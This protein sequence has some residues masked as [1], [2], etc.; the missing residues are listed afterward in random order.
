MN[1]FNDATAIG[2]MKAKKESLGFQYPVDFFKRCE[3]ISSR[4][5]YVLKHPHTAHQ[6]KFVIFKRQFHGLSGICCYKIKKLVFCEHG[7]RGR[8][9]EAKCCCFLII[10]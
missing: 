9:T 2:K 8:F 1:N 10:V 7:M 3:L 4:F 5:V 6:I